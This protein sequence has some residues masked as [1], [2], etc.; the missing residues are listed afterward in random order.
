MQTQWHDTP[1]HHSIQTRG[2]PVVLLSIDVSSL[3]YFSFMKIPHNAGSVRSCI[4]ILKM[5][6]ESTGRIPKGKNHWSR[7]CRAKRDGP[8][9]LIISFLSFF[10]RTPTY[11]N[12]YVEMIWIWYAIIFEYFYNPRHNT[13]LDISC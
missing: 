13:L 11:L 2:R 3:R 9:Q 4:I 1:T 8:P 7:K 12:W 5:K 6:P 10:S